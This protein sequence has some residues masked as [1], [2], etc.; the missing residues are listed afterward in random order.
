MKRLNLRNV[1]FNRLP[2]EHLTP[3]EIWLT[4]G[5]D[6]LTKRPKN[7]PYDFEIYKSVEVAIQE[8]IINIDGVEGGCCPKGIFDDDQDAVNNNL[9]EGD[10]Y[11]LSDTNT[12]GSDFNGL[13]K[14]VRAGVFINASVLGTD[15]LNGSESIILGTG[16][17]DI[18]GN[19]IVL[20]TN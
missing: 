20:G 1:A 8:G 12:L 9:T 5:P 11:E 19:P 7:S 14:V 4:E 10:V 17:T 13:L 15:Q 16:Q 2:D 6:A 18:N 3:R